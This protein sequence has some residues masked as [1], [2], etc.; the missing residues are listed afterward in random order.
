M[1]ICWRIKVTLVGSSR[2]GKTSFIKGRAD[3]EIERF[4]SS[5][6]LGVSFEI[7]DS[8]LENGEICR[9]CVWDINQRARHPAI[10]P[11]FFR[12]AAGSILFFDLSRNQTFEDLK[13]W[14][15]L[16]RKIN[17]NIPL[18]LIGTNDDL[19]PEVFPEDIDDFVRINGILGYYP[20]TIY[21]ESKRDKVF[22]YLIADIIEKRTIGASNNDQIEP[23]EESIETLLNQLDRRV[24]HRENI[25][26][27]YYD[28]LTGKEKATCDQFMEYFASCPIC[29]A[30]NHISYLKKIYFSK[31]RKTIELKNQLLKLLEISEDFDRFFSNNIILGIPCCNCFQTFFDEKAP[32]LGNIGD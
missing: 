26:D 27:E 19:E 24:Y 23:V 9:C 18:F 8:F 17:G 6:A 13:I 10:Y 29:K 20:T 4:S 14:I 2:V 7:L 12:G 25:A 30:E 11:V 28:S 15:K 3:F 31:N 16:I 22:Q 32:A 5:R 1:S 21:G